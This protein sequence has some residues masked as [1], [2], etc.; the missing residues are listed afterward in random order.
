M[1][2]E[3][4]IRHIYLFL[5]LFPTYAIGK[6]NCPTLTTSLTNPNSDANCYY[7]MP[8]PHLQKALA[9]AICEIEATSSKRKIRFLL[10]MHGICTILNST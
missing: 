3:N 1:C 4:C 8:Q 7:S 5:Y 10:S 2:L 9:T 6:S